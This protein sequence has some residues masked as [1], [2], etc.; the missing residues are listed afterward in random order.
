MQ[1]FLSLAALA[2]AT[3]VALPA[4]AQFRDAD[5]AVQ[6]RQSA[7]TLMATHFGRI[8]AMAQGKVPFDAKLAV[9]NAEVVAMVSKLPFAAFGPGTDK[10]S[11]RS[12]EA[13]PAVWAEAAKFKAGADKLN[14]ESTKLLAAARS[15]NLDQ[16]KA[17]VG[18][19]GQSCKSCHDS[20][21]KD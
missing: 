15:G 17:A 18:G 5:H 12:T 3:L 21:K 20:F 1:R 6:Y 11:K 8:N 16:I 19:V 13:K 2:A 10:P 4:Q 7:F 9:E 14:E